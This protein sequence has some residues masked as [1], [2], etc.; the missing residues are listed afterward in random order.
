MQSCLLM[1][2]ILILN[3]CLLTLC[4]FLWLNFSKLCLSYWCLYLTWPEKSFALSVKAFCKLGN[5][6]YQIKAKMLQKI[7]AYVG[8]V[9]RHFW[10]VCG[11]CRQDISV[12]LFM[13]DMFYVFLFLFR[14]KREDNQK[15]FSQ[16]GLQLHHSPPQQRRQ[17]AVC[18]CPRD[19]LCSQP[20]WHQW[21][22]VTEKCKS[23]VSVA[24]WM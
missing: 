5:I 19:T 3:L 18:W 8:D 22:Q 12:R 21:S 2:F 1:P 10:M 16:W 9:L 24:K 11:L 4:I 14:C 23:Q 17:H 13:S 15:F 20:Q 7:S 6:F